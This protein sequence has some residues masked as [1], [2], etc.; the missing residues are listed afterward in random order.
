MAT[1]KVYTVD[2]AY[3]RY[4]SV[5]ASPDSASLSAQNLVDGD[6]N[7]T[8]EPGASTT[9]VRIIHA[10]SL[11]IRGYG[12]AN[13]NLLG[14]VV[15]VHVIYDG[16]QHE[17]DIY[18]PVVTS[19]DFLVDWGAPQVAATETHLVIQSTG[20]DIQI[21]CLSIIAD[22]GYNAAGELV[23][24]EGFGIIEFGGD[25]AGGMPRPLPVGGDS[26]VRVLR[27]ANGFPQFQRLG[28]PVQSFVLPFELMRVAR[29]YELWRLWNAYYP[30]RRGAFANLGFAGRVWY[31]SDDYTLDAPMDR[32]C[33]GMPDSQPRYQIDYA[34]SRSSGSLYLETLPRDSVA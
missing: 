7:S 17:I 26:G 25:D 24:G 15:S 9:E 10:S 22:Y 33:V 2:L 3:K 28:S 12:I 5:S 1:P 21:G 13:H 11:R 32:Y 16:G 34:G 23:E 29:D 27:S 19:E 30:M 20:A 4:S 31:T 18:R 14:G 6:P 8:F